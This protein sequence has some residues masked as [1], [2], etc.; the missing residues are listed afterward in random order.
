VPKLRWFA[1]IPIVSL[2]LAG[3]MAPAMTGAQSKNGQ[4]PKAKAAEKWCVRVAINN[5]T[6]VWLKRKQLT[7]QQLHAKDAT[8][9]LANAAAFV[10]GRGGSV[11]VFDDE[12]DRCHQFTQ[13]P[14][15]QTVGNEGRCATRALANAT[16]WYVV[17]FADRGLTDPTRSIDVDKVHVWITV[18]EDA[19]ENRWMNEGVWAKVSTFDAIRIFDRDFK[20]CVGRGAK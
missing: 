15:G 20:A 10:R 6:G 3:A 16:G 9:Y 7:R 14:G 13:H 12:I 11:V 5:S 17:D 4:S 2:L 8:G 19:P 18:A 1:V